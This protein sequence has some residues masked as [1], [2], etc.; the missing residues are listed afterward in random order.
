MIDVDDT[1]I[2]TLYRHNDP[3][4]WYLVLNAA[5]YTT[6]YRGLLGLNKAIPGADV[7]ISCHILSRRCV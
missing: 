7:P 6:K 5:G 3:N 2:E 4:K 1:Q